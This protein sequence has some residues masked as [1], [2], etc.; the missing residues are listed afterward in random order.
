MRR[1]GSWLTMATAAGCMLRVAAARAAVVDAGAPE[2]EYT[3]AP[4][5]DAAYRFRAR[6]PGGEGGEG[7]A[8]TATSAV[9]P[10]LGGTL[11]RPWLRFQGE[12]E[13]AAGPP[14]LLAS[15]LE[16]QPLD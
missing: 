3:P 7:E 13:L 14:S 9:R 4:G 1:R 12:A 8:A 2:I 16:M 11:M 10:S 6:R 5:L 15:Y